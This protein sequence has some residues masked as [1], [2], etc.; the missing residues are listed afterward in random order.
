MNS[1]SVQEIETDQPGLYGF[2]ITGEVDREDMREMSEHMLAAFDRHDKV[3]MLLV[4]ETD[5]TATTDSSLSS[6]SLKAQFQSLSKVRNYVVANAPG[7]AGGIVETMG[8]LMP[9][10]ARSFDT[11]EDARAWLR[12]QPPLAA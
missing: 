1:T 2:R 10:D 12:E 4:F 11:E 6:E 5:K 3:D 9:V 8:K 7:Q